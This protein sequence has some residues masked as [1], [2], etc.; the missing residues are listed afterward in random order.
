[1][2]VRERAILGSADAFLAGLV[3]ITPILRV[4]YLRVYRLIRAPHRRA[5]LARSGEH[6]RRA[7][8]EI[9]RALDHD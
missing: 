4:K 9:R 1:M 5:D 2:V 3:S 8:R 7:D 6:A